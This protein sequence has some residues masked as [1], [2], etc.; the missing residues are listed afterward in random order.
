MKCNFIIEKGNIKY[1]HTRYIETEILF[2]LAFVGQSRNVVRMLKAVLE[3]L[4]F[5]VEKTDS[6]QIF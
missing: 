1:I 4:N 3:F 6:F 2:S 5:L